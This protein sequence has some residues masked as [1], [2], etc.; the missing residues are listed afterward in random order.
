VEKVIVSENAI[1]AMKL[2]LTTNHALAR[3]DIVLVV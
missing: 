1:S 2:A 3:V